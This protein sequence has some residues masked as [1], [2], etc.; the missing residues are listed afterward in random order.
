MEDLK[1]ISTSQRHRN[2]FIQNVFPLSLYIWYTLSLGFA[3]GFFFFFLLLLLV[4]FVVNAQVCLYCTWWNR[5]LAISN[6]IDGKRLSSSSVWLRLVYALVCVESSHRENRGFNSICRLC[7]N[8][9]AERRFH[10]ITSNNLKCQIHSEYL[11]RE[12]GNQHWICTERNSDNNTQAM[13]MTMSA[14][15]LQQQATFA[16]FH[17]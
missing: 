3:L 9:S 2:E 5:T 10:T 11:S 4:V 14:D 16:Y 1:T 7:M 15:C 13:T 12:N 17:F 8:D 6:W